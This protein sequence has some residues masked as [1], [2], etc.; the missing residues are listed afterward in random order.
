MTMHSRLFRK[1]FDPLQVSSNLSEVKCN[2]DV[3]CCNFLL[4]RN[5]GWVK[6]RI[7]AL[8]GS[9]SFLNLAFILRQ[10]ALM[11]RVC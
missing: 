9:R 8:S 11:V 1:P 3:Y 10:K 4:R 5:I 7:S 6:G 2:S